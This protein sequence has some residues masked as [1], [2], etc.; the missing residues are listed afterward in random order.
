MEESCAK[1]IGKTTASQAM[2]MHLAGKKVDKPS[3]FFGFFQPIFDH[4]DLFRFS[5]V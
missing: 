5:G 3:S 2:L 1:N 4:A